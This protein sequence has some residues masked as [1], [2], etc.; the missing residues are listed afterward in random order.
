MLIGPDD[1]D[2]PVFHTTRI[3]CE[4]AVDFA[5]SESRVGASG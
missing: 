3:H 4:S 2:L 1:I 5:L